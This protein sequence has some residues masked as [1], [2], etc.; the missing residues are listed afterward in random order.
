MQKLYPQTEKE[1]AQVSAKFLKWEYHF[2]DRKNAFVA[3]QVRIWVLEGPC[4]NL[5]SEFPWELASE[6]AGPLHGRKS[7]SSSVLALADPETTLS[8]LLGF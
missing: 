7:A 6:L 8:I 4:Q 3:W 1:T 5:R 2:H